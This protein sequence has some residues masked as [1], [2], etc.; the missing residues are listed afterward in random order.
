MSATGQTRTFGN[1]VAN[2]GFGA[3]SGSQWAGVRESTVSGSPAVPG[4]FEVIFRAVERPYCLS[5]L[6]IRS[7]GTPYNETANCAAF[8]VAFLDP[9]HPSPP[10]PREKL[11][12]GWGDLL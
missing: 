7:K 2:V 8:P 11:A 3:E 1:A 9:V 4:R 5:V 12:D 6:L 10:E